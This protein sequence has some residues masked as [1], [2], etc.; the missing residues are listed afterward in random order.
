MEEKLVANESNW[1]VNKL[2]CRGGLESK[3]ITSQIKEGMTQREVPTDVELSSLNWTLTKEVMF[4][5]RS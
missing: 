4:N 3:S 5:I 1:P 2:S